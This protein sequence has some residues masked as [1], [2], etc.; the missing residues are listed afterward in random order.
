MSFQGKVLEYNSQISNSPKETK[1]SYF[2]KN[3]WLEYSHTLLPNLD[4]SLKLSSIE[5]KDV[6]KGYYK[7]IGVNSRDEYGWIC[8]YSTVPQFTERRKGVI[9]LLKEDRV[10]L[11]KPLIKSPNLEI[12]MYAIDA[13]IYHDYKTTQIIINDIIPE[14]T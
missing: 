12:S 6:L 3:V 4:D 9:E 5:S 10:D 7:L 2:D 14:L 8:E 13:M 11:I 1:T